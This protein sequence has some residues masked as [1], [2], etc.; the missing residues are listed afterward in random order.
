MTTLTASSARAKLSTLLRRALKGDE[1]G[2]VMD[3][4]IVALR[5]VAVEATDYATREYGVTES[6]LEAFE[7]RTHEKIAKARKAGKL[8]DFTGDVESLV[9]G[10]GH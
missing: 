6:E 10:P 3:G 5:P 2:I 4:K 7:K 1:I 9:A 8:A